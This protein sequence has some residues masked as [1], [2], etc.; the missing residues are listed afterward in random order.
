MKVPNIVIG[1]RVEENKVARARAMRR[2]MTPAESALWKCLKNNQLGGFHFR[3]QQIIK[4]FIVDFYCHAAVLV[5]EVDGGVH[6]DMKASDAER[7]RILEGL[8][9]KVLRFSNTDVLNVTNQV[10]DRIS[11][12]LRD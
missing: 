1:Q 10:L 3:R 2:S 11:R 6:D 12:A 8:G 9:F 4:G 7:D 5:V